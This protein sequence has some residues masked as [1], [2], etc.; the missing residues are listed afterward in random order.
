VS[1]GECVIL[2]DHC[3]VT[4]T[5]RTHSLRNGRDGAT[6]MGKGKLERTEYLPP[7]ICRKVSRSLMGE[8][9]YHKVSQSINKYLEVH[10]VSWGLT[11][12]HSKYHEVKIKVS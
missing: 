4:P 10:K 7:Y 9:K 6:E 5:E 2:C 3:D 11:K 1:T 8:L 12:Y